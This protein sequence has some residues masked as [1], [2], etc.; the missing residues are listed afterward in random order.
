MGGSAMGGTVGGGAT[1]GGGVG[2]RG[3]GGASHLNAPCSGLC[4]NPVVI[5][6]GAGYSSGSLGT[7][8]SCFEVEEPIAGGSCSNFV[9]PRTLHVNGAIEPCDTGGNW[10]LLPPTRYG[11][12]CIKVTAGD[13]PSANFTLW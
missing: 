7:G 9:N 10:R 1:G 4:P 5:D 6:V 12:Y 11:G 13:Q 2:G 3:T 8:A